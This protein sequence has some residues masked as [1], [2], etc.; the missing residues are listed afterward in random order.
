MFI[1]GNKR[2][3]VAR[4]EDKVNL[5]RNRSQI[6]AREKENNV[7]SF[8]IGS[9]SKNVETQLVIYNKKLEQGG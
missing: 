3:K 1:M 5:K 6:E 4:R 7:F 9:Y 8:N 2:K